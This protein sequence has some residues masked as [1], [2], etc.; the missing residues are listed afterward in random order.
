MSY[1]DALLVWI[2]A[3][4]SSVESAINLSRTS[5]SSCACI[6]GVG[7]CGTHKRSRHQPQTLYRKYFARHQ[8]GDCA[9]KYLYLFL[10]QSHEYHCIESSY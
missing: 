6:L 10:E 9:T 4:R 7:I 2:V 3:T 8:V 5:T 1:A